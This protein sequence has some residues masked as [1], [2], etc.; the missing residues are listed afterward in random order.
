M[1]TNDVKAIARTILGSDSK[2]YNGRLVPSNETLKC[3]VNDLSLRH[4]L[5]HKE[6][7]EMISTDAAQV[8]II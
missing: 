2:R 1:S 4:D 7:N 6:H 5:S 8:I 3:D